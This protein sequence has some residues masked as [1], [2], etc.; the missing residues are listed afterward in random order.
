[1]AFVGRKKSLEEV[2]AKAMP[3]VVRFN[4]IKRKPILAQREDFLFYFRVLREMFLSAEI[5]RQHV[6]CKH[7]VCSS[8]WRGNVHFFIDSNGQ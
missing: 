6:N 2:R 1:M 3:I 8:R 5:Y 4:L 7:E